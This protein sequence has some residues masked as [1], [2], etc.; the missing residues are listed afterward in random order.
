MSKESAHNRAGLC[1]NQASC[2]FKP[3]DAIA[4]AQHSAPV[5]QAH[6]QQLPVH[7]CQRLAQGGHVSGPAVNVQL[8]T[9]L[10]LPAGHGQHNTVLMEFC[11][12]NKRL[13]SMLLEQ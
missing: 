7:C 9:Q 11:L 5:N 8:P 1:T 10:K 13:L 12:P 6:L 3:V 4:T 2:L